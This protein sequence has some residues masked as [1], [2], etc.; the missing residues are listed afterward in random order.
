MKDMDRRENKENVKGK[1]NLTEP[2]YKSWIH[3]IL[4][5]ERVKL[6]KDLSTISNRKDKSSFF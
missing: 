4:A 6:K 2:E 1:E 3:N 5:N